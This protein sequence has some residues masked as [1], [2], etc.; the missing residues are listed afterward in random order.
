[1]NKLDKL[2]D[3]AKQENIF[4]YF[5]ADIPNYEADALFVARNGSRVI[6]ILKHLQNNVSRLTEIL[7]EELGHYFTSTGENILPVNYFDRLKIGKCENKALKWA[8]DFLIPT[9]DL[10]DSF[11]RN[12]Y[13]DSIDLIAEDLNVSRDILIQKLYFLSLKNDFLKLNG[14]KYIVLSN[15][16][17]IYPFE[18]I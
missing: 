13:T 9:N 12:F 17:S 18:K 16:P 2:L 7:A 6:L 8:C 15:F 10:I 3:L 1:M 14:N 5:V 11:L 4:I